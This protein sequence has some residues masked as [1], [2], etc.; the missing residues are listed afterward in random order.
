MRLKKLLLVMLIIIVF[1]FSLMLTTS[2]AWYSFERG[3]TTFDAETEVEDIFVS[4]QDGEYINT[5]IAVPVVGDMVDKYSSKNNFNIKVTGDGEVMVGVS[6]IE[7]KID[8]ALNK[9]SFVIDLFYQ[10]SKIDTITGSKIVTG[11]DIVFKNVLLENID[12]NQFEVRMYILDDGSVQNE[13]MSKVFSAKVK[14]DVVSRLNPEFVD[15]EN[16]DISIDSITIDGEVSDNLPTDGYYSMTSSCN[17]GSKLSWEPLSKMLTYVKGSIVGDA[18]KL[19]FTSSKDYPLLNKMREGSYVKY[20]GNNGCDG[21]NCSG[22]NPNYV[23]DNMMGYCGD[24]NYQYMNNGFRLFYKDGDNAYLVSAGAV[25]C[26][27]LNSDGSTSSDVCDNSLENPD[28]NLL[29]DNMNK[30]ALRYCN[31]N[32]IDGGVCD[33]TTVW[34]MNT[35]DFEKV[36]GTT[37]YYNNEEDKSCYENSGNKVCGYN[38]DLIDNGGFYWISNDNNKVFNWN[39]NYRRVSS[40]VNFA[41]GVRPVLKLDAKVAVVSGSGTYEDPYVITK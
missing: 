2:Y 18:C 9:D 32:Y 12:S 13:M 14:I 40:N 11:T 31:K 6:L 27:C 17:K 41:N 34:N 23:N 10:G 29:V 8:E 25:D 19:V 39:A 4:Y 26:M 20:V 22:K 24:V 3:S 33:N 28:I 16:P 35:S 5:D 38:N 1:M 37:L 30:I 36:L 15:Y 7:V 21:D